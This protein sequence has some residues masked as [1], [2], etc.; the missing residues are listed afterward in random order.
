MRR[1]DPATGTL[2]TADSKL[3]SLAT[4][5]RP[6]NAAPAPPGLPPDWEAVEAPFIIHHG[7]YY[8]LFVSWDLC[9]RGTKSNYRSMAA[10][11]G[12]QVLTPNQRWL[13]PGGESLYVGKD[14]TIMV[15]HAYDA[16][17]GKPALQISTIGW[18]NEWP[19][20]ALQG[21]TANK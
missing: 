4:R 15:F 20:V 12:T 11:G 1:I 6:E 14:Q 21:D 3:Y 5:E 13:G 2:S 16:Q 9:C 7:H 18:K 8:Y 17:T 19:L 10:G